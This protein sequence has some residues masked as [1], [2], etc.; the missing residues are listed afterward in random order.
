MSL[1][2]D[3]RG[4]PRGC[5]LSGLNLDIVSRC[6][7]V[8]Q[9][10]RLQRRPVRSHRGHCPYLSPPRSSSDWRRP[11]CP[12][13]SVSA[14]AD[15]RSSSDACSVDHHMSCTDRLTDGIFNNKPIVSGYSGYSLSRFDSKWTSTKHSRLTICNIIRRQPHLG[16]PLTVQSGFESDGNA[17]ERRSRSFL[18]NGNVVPVVFLLYTPIVNLLTVIFHGSPSVI[19][20]ICLIYVFMCMISWMIRPPCEISDQLAVGTQTCFST[21]FY[22]P[23]TN[24]K[25]SSQNAPKC[26]IARHKNPNIF[27]G[28]ARPSSHTPPPLGRGYP[29]PRPH[30]LGAF[31]A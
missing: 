24:I 14:A 1:L 28:E 15:A 17:R 5:C 2:T 27:G 19:K 3:R 23:Y 9:C 16:L 26:T 12:R 25:T 21:L 10:H 11:E 20:L 22:T 31:G 6:R 7:C 30:P 8:L 29:L 4:S 18:Y 13:F